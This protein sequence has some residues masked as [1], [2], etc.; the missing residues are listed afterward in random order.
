MLIKHL[1]AVR[2]AAGSAVVVAAVG[3]VEEGVAGMEVVADTVNDMFQ[4]LELF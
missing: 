3:M 2:A 1:S 4:P